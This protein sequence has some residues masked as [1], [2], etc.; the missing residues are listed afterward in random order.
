MQDVAGHVLYKFFFFRKG[1][2]IYENPHRTLMRDIEK[3]QEW[4]NHS[5]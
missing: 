5:P 4:K 2:H 3:G 1:L